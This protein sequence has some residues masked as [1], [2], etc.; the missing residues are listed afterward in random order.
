C[1]VWYRDGEREELS[2]RRF[3]LLR[4]HSRWRSQLLVLQEPVSATRIEVGSYDRDDD[5][6]FGST[7]KVAWGGTA[8]QVGLNLLAKAIARHVE[9][10]WNAAHRVRDCSGSNGSGGG[11]SAW[12]GATAAAAARVQSIRIDCVVDGNGTLWLCSAS[13][14]A[15]H[16]SSHNGTDRT[17][18][19][20]TPAPEVQRA[21][22]AVATELR[23]VLRVA[24][25]RHVQVDA[26]FEHF[27]MEGRGFVDAAQLQRGLDRLGMAVAPP[28]ADALVGSIGEASSA[29]FRA[30]DLAA[31]VQD[32]QADFRRWIELA[33]WARKNTRKALEE[34]LRH[35]P[36]RHTKRRRRL[37]NDA[38]TLGTATEEQ[39]LDGPSP[40][41]QEQR[42]GETREK[43]LGSDAVDSENDGGSG[44][45]NGDGSISGSGDGGS[46]N[47]YGSFRLRPVVRPLDLAPLA[48]TG[49][50]TRASP[51]ASAAAIDSRDESLH[52]GGGVMVTFRWV[53][54]RA[55][56]GRSATGN[57][58]EKSAT[59]RA[60]ADA[61][62]CAGGVTAG[63]ASLPRDVTLVAVPGLFMTLDSMEVGIGSVLDVLPHGRLLLVGLPGMPGTVWPQRA[64]LNAQ[65]AAKALAGLLE[66]LQAHGLLATLPKAAKRTAVGAAFAPVLLVGFGTGAAAAAAFASEHLGRPEHAKL[67]QVLCTVIL[68]NPMPA[69][70]A[71]A[72]STAHR[73]LQRAL[74]AV[75]AVLRRGQHHEQVHLLAD[76]LLSSEYLAAAG[77]KSALETFWAPRRAL[78]LSHGA[79]G[80]AAAGLAA[81]VDG[82][83]ATSGGLVELAAGVA[84]PLVLLRSTR[85]I[86]V[87][88]DAARLLREAWPAEEAAS[89]AVLAGGGGGGQ[90]RRM[91]LVREVEAGHELL[92]EAPSALRAV[93]VESFGATEDQPLWEDR[94]SPIIEMED[95]LDVLQGDGGNG[96]A[97]TEDDD[98]M[99]AAVLNLQEEDPIAIPAAAGDAPAELPVAATEPP[100]AMVAVV[101]DPRPP[102]SSPSVRQRKPGQSSRRRQRQREVDALRR[103]EAAAVDRRRESDERMAMAAEE[104]HSVA[105]EMYEEA[106]AI[107]AADVAGAR[108]RA[109]ELRAA[110][111]ERLLRTAE[112][113]VARQRSAKHLDRVHNVEQ[114]RVRELAAA[115]TGDCGGGAAELGRV[116]DTAAAGQATDA[117]V[118]RVAAV[119]RH[120]VEAMRQHDARTE[121]HR[122]F[123]GQ[124][125]RAEEELKA[126]KRRQRTAAGASRLA[127]AAAARVAAAASPAA[128]A[129]EEHLTLLRSVLSERAALLTFAERRL[130]ALK[131]SLRRAELSAVRTVAR[132]RRRVHS[133]HE[134]VG[135]KRAAKE[136]TVRHKR[137]L[138]EE[139]SVTETRAAELAAEHRMLQ[140]HRGL[141]VDTDVWQAGVMQR[142]RT[143]EL[144]EYLRDEQR[145]LG[146]LLAGANHRMSDLNT[147]L[148]RNAR[149]S[150]A[151]DEVVQRLMR[152]AAA[153]DERF[154]AITARPVLQEYRALVAAEGDAL[155]ATPPPPPGTGAAAATVRAKPSYLRSP[156]EKRWVGLDHLLHPHLYE[157]VPDVEAEELLLD[158]GY[159][160]DLA[161]EDIR[162]IAGLLPGL[163]HAMPMLRNAAEVEAHGLIMTYGAGIGDT[164]LC[165]ADEA[166]EA[167]AAAAEAKA[168]EAA[169]KAAAAASL[170][171]GE[172]MEENAAEME[173]GDG[174]GND[175]VLLFDTLADVISTDFDPSRPLTA[176]MLVRNGEISLA[177]VPWQQLA[178]R[179]SRL[180]YFNAAT[181][182]EGD[183]LVELTVTISFRGCMGLRGFRLGR[184][185]ADLLRLHEGGGDRS[186]GSGTSVGFAPHS[187]AVSNAGDEFLQRDGRLVIVHRTAAPPLRPGRFCLVV[188]AAAPTKYS[189]TIIARVATWC[190]ALVARRL[191]E[192]TDAQQQL[193]AAEEERRR[194]TES[195]RLQERK[196]GICRQLMD[197]AEAEMGRCAGGI[198]DLCRRLDAAEHEAE[199]AAEAESCRL[200]ILSSPDRN[201]FDG[202][203]RRSGRNGNGSNGGGNDASSSLKAS[204]AASGT[205]IT[206]DS[207]AL[208]K[209]VAGLEL[210]YAHWARL[211]TTRWQEKAA[212][213]R[214]VERLLQLLRRHGTEAAA[215]RATVEAARR[216]VPTATAMLHGAK[217]ATEAAL[218]LDT[219]LL[220]HAA[221]QKWVTVAALK[222]VLTSFLTPAQ[223]VRGMH[224]REG[225]RALTLEEQQWSLMD[226]A[227]H[228]EHYG[229][230]RERD[231]ARAARRERRGLR[232]NP[233]RLLGAAVEPFR[234][235]PD[236]LRRILSTPPS[237]LTRRETQACKL[238]ARFHDSPRLLRRRARDL[239][240]E[241]AGDGAGAGPGNPLAERTRAKDPRARTAEE[242]QWC[243]VDRVLNPG[244][245]ALYRAERGGVAA[246]TL[247]VATAAGNEAKK[248]GGVSNGGYGDQWV[249][250]FSRDELLLIWQGRENLIEEPLSGDAAIVRRVLKKYNGKAE[251]YLAWEVDAAKRRA[252]RLVE[253]VDERCRAVLQEIDRVAHNSNPVMDS[254]LLHGAAPQR[255]PTAVLR[256]ELEG[257]LDRLLRLQ[258]LERE[259]KDFYLLE[260]CSSD[261][262]SNDND[263][264]GDGAD[265]DAG[266]GDG[267]TASGL[268]ETS[269]RTRKARQRARRRAGRR[270]VDAA[271]NLHITRKRLVLD[272]GSSR[273][274]KRSSAQ[275]EEVQRLDALGPGGCLACDATACRWRQ[276]LDA[277]AGRARAAALSDELLVVRGAPAAAT[278]LTSVVPASVGKGG[279]PIFKREDLEHELSWELRHVRFMVRLSAIDAE[280]H[281]A[282]RTT[283][284]FFECHALHGYRT[285]LWTADARRALDAEQSRLLARLVAVEVV[286][287]ILQDMLEGWQFGERP[288]PPK[289][290][291]KKRKHY[292]DDGKRIGDDLVNEEK[293]RAT[294]DAEEDRVTSFMLPPG[295]PGSAWAPSDEK[296]TKPGGPHDLALRR[297][298]RDV[299]FAMFLLTLM[300]FR[301]MALLRTQR[302]ARREMEEEPLLDF[303]VP[304]GGRVAKAEAAA[305]RA[306]QP[307]QLRVRQ[308]TETE[309]RETLG[310]FGRY[311]ALRRAEESAAALLQRLYRGHIARKAARRWAG[312]QHRHAAKHARMCAAALMVQRAWRGRRG[313]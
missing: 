152:I 62:H 233:P 186:G 307:G 286:D 225:W 171:A 17:N 46:S 130:Q 252:E 272:R 239:Q 163:Q 194:A 85:D 167:T 215:L 312:C 238:I 313:R 220:S 140:S 217:R 231:A 290:K 37:R 304:V 132:V 226:Q 144:R 58:L 224:Q 259:R 1:V 119:R 67:R 141:Y 205:T 287:G 292:D 133:L 291:K 78:G 22:A 114:A 104:E 262:D 64:S 57:A 136:Q 43:Q 199:A 206:A 159:A 179:Q 170:E 305:S 14:L 245:W 135:R 273:T 16:I 289:K 95:L 264:D 222:D 185:G 131:G 69:A 15:M 214:Q 218:Q 18:A 143:D 94:D 157:G 40:E 288:N 88:A 111:E 80:A 193:A 242:W 274:K 100:A 174:S 201:D 65:V 187:A 309:R 26:L 266:G 234:F 232:R 296:V 246:G 49:D 276:L 301:G 24:V 20:D 146:A 204:S 93:V 38:A 229:W 202:N 32:P 277:D 5:P 154:A 36:R 162:R 195:M 172:K 33:P 156:E 164:A 207:V 11:S 7:G 182:R 263:R 285:M 56:V 75:A 191:A 105:A 280:L 47:A 151:V 270:A 41:P 300:Y 139:L 45:S 19:D 59:M 237:G 243:A 184:L 216:E 227:L 3:D 298:E 10:T 211:F 71:V 13:K 29:F 115:A 209:D 180:H 241:Q 235:H 128:A 76:L 92:Q 121:Q 98:G 161:A 35:A 247:A 120:V 99:N 12:K 108:C 165:R 178:F 6:V 158:G 306:A 258:V 145:R 42:E 302:H 212:I 308:R 255:F 23:R 228:P 279:S 30:L 91:F 203:G 118:E 122:L 77:R 89:A 112:D 25:A 142:V 102:S 50:Y 96:L 52:V 107:W 74:S 34:L 271:E 269:W 73:S 281:T 4:T 223:E 198:D 70:G 254:C 39:E 173:N 256:L 117:A 278:V 153:A 188:R 123:R 9:R 81:A 236:E 129:A 250:P 166:A 260:D 311:S 294:R 68:V 101:A 200:D 97:G 268:L 103:D 176:A 175:S 150:Q 134:E 210:E 261:S 249:C 160:T 192:A 253:G 61:L 90:H 284:D 109:A 267:N 230:L 282:G 240:R 83:A 2:L 295:A 125:A 127:A 54:R 244:V 106:C 190:G 155:L 79:P 84:V 196:L 63:A 116:M 31:F 303:A 177:S 169:G 66:H 310:N 248:R 126:L 44:G 283:A 181:G 124:A 213:K 53:V 8:T 149:E 148:L 27:D 28:V 138:E 168:F 197:E 251:E 110:R 219:S 86:L 293:E 82:A 189:V 55:A 137:A 72:A 297:T 147:A 275:L 221:A 257:E 48:D 265:E 208:W 299:R 21:A 60:A 183:C 51:P 113:D 87:R